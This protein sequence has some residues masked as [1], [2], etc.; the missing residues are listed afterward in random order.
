MTI[1]YRDRP[2]MNHDQKVRAL[3][4][5]LAMNQLVT[6]AATYGLTVEHEGWS[7]SIKGR[8]KLGRKVEQQAATIAQAHWMVLDAACH[9]KPV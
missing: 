7:I 6:L 8:D 9:D 5:G 1:P 3:R 2:I 4:Q